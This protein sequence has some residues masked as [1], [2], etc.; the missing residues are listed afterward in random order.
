MA[1]EETPPGSS[2]YTSSGAFFE[3]VGPVHVRGEGDERVFALR[4]EERHGNLGG[5]A[6]GGLLAALVDFA[7]GRAI[8]A[9]TGEDGAPATVSLTTDF[10]RLVRP[11]DW[12]EAHTEVERIGRTLAFADCSL[13]VE[14]REVVRGRAVYAV[15]AR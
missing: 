14:G 8:G 12:V 1:D 9:E 10:L 7:L 2:P 3:L 11:G 5:S 15:V 4:V 13:T 6:H